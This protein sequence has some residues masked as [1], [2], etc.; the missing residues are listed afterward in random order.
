M[1]TLWRGAAVCASV[2]ASVTVLLA[3]APSGQ[4]RAAA[5]KQALAANKVALRQYTWVE[6]TDIALKGEDKKQER[7]QCAYATDG[8]V[9]KTPLPDQSAQPQAQEKSESRRRGGGAL[10]KAIVSNKIDDMKDYMAKVKALVQEYVPPDAAKVQSVQAAGNM[11][12][13]P[14]SSGAMLTLKDYLKPGDSIAIGLDPKGTAIQTFKVMSYVE[15]PKEDD[16]T[17][18]VTY[19]TLPDGTSY[20]QRT[21]LDVTAKKIGV[22]VTNSDYRKVGS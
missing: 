14:S 12:I 21:V 6:T 13:E 5:L 8:S 10:K 19:G 3:Q 4:D 16:V 20:P 22:T 18:S 17:L 9:T 11:S 2:A 15:K 7:K 1:T